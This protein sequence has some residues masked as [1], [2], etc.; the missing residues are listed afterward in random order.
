MRNA[1]Q[2]QFSNPNYHLFLQFG[3]ETD[4]TIAD[5]VADLRAPT[6]SAAAE[7]AVPEISK[8]EEGIQSYKN[9]YRVALKKKVDYMKLQYEKCMQARCYK[10]PLQGINEKYINIDMLVKN[11]AD[12][13]I[14]KLVISRKDFE[15]SITKIDALSPLKTLQRGYS[16]AKKGEKIV[17]SV[18]ELQTGD[19]ICIRFIDGEKS[20]KII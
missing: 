8:I 17:K 14:K 13:A 2:E 9:R 15:G 19:E 10:E 12:N 20:A 5:F 18:K 6:P 1:S 7:L 11:M 3:H 4:F 16:I